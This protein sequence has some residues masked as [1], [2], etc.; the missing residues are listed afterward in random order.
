MYN[1]KKG[2]NNKSSINVMF[3]ESNVF[4]DNDTMEGGNSYFNQFRKELHSE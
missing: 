3:S 1:S 2:I 4:K